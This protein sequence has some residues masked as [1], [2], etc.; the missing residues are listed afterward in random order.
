MK[1]RAYTLSEIDR[2]RRAMAVICE[3]G[4]TGRT[5]MATAAI[6]LDNMAQAQL[7]E[8]R[9]RTAMLGGVKPRELEVDAD[10]HA[11]Q[12]IRELGPA[13]AHWYLPLARS[14]IVERKIHI[15]IAYVR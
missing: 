4:P 13:H 2:M 15:S 11:A 14:W 7:I 12:S 8:E 5:G 9:I 10:L 1:E 6:I 3:P